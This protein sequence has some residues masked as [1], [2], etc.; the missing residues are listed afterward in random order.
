MN[1][2]RCPVVIQNFTC[3]P[4]TTFNRV[5]LCQL[6]PLLQITPLPAER[7]QPRRAAGKTGTSAH[8]PAAEGDPR[9]R[10]LIDVFRCL[11]HYCNR[12]CS[13]QLTPGVG[14][15]A[16][17]CRSYYCGQL[18]GPAVR[19]PVFRLAGGKIGRIGVLRITIIM[20]VLMDAACLFAWNGWS[21]LVIRFLQ[22]WV[23]VR[24]VPLPA[25]IS[26]NLSE[27]RSAGVSFVV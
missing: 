22:G 19:R 17:V 15:H 23:S 12:I 24:E 3:M 21:I 20:F 16:D 1:K 26:M 6:R 11:Y 4:Q 2:V 25:P 7:R 8:H 14:P 10:R 9:Y 5:I 13:P 18:R 27:Q